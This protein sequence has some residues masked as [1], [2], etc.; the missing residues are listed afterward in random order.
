MILAS[1]PSLTDEDIEYVRGKARTV[2]V[3]TTYLRAL[4]ADVHYFCDPQWWRWH[5]DDPEWDKFEGERITLEHSAKQRPTPYPAM[6]NGG[7]VGFDERRDHL[8]TGR[9]S[10]YQAVHLVAHYAA[11]PIVL[12][13][14][15]MKPDKAGNV[16]WHPCHP[17]ATRPGVINAAWI[18]H[19][20]SL[21][22]PLHAQGIQVINCTRDTALKAFPVK[23]LADVL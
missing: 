6:L 5:K 4:W 18:K 1:G 17:T 22:E 19:W 2:V 9:N 3:N 20:S 21:A 13:G 8:R 7:T 12:L 11:S 23:P 14:F 15:D 10:G 16:H